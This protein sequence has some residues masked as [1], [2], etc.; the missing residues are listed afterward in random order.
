MP[1]G[2]THEQYRPL[3]SY[4]NNIDSSYSA[5]DAPLSEDNLRESL[6]AA[7]RLA[8]ND[9]GANDQAIEDFLMSLSKLRVEVNVVE[10]CHHVSPFDP[11]AWQFLAQYV[12]CETWREEVPISY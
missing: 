3:R 2:L 12:L 1:R 4:L 7:I 5:L 9:H 8:V 6:P 11:A 10:G